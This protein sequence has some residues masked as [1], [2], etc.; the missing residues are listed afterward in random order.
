M[1]KTLVTKS[2]C[3]YMSMKSLAVMEHL[4]FNRTSETWFRDLKPV[5]K[6]TVLDFFFPFHSFLLICTASIPSKV[7]SLHIQVAIA[8]VTAVSILSHLSIL[9]LFRRFSQ[10]VQVDPRTSLSRTQC[11]NRASHCVQ[12]GMEK[13]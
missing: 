4:S 1:Q 7:S 8:P 13:E 10:L 12:A 6:C 9:L 11:L 5:Y 2:P 3:W